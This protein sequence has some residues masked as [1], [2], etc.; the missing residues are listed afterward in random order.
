[1]RF[2]DYNSSQI[3]PQTTLLK[4]FQMLIKWLLENGEDYI[5]D[6]FEVKANYVSGNNIER[7]K[8]V[9][10]DVKKCKEGDLLVF[11]NC[12]YAFV[13]SLNEET[14]YFGDVVDFRYHLYLHKVQLG[15]D[16]HFGVYQ[17]LYFIDNNPE[18]VETYS[19]AFARSALAL[20]AYLEVKFM[21]TRYRSLLVTITNTQ[22]EVTEISSAMSSRTLETEIITASDLGDFIFDVVTEY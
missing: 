5:P 6:L 22:L 11:L 19:E 3:V 17:Y 18:P 1:M 13:T 16:L 12:H 21:D 4:K 10:T 2:K 8:I 9:E 20:D 15:T 14:I 7:N